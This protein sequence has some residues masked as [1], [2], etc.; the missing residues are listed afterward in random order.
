MSG[1]SG[2][3][4]PAVAI[5]S[6]MAGVV[7]LTSGDLIA[8]DLLRIYSPF[9]LMLARG[10]FAFVPLLIALHLTGT[11]SRLPTRRPVAQAGRGLAMATAYCCYL[12]ALRT[13]PMADATALMFAAPFMVAGLSRLVLGERVSPARWAAIAVGFAGV[14]VVAQP[15]GAGFRAEGLWA[16]GG[17]GALA[18]A[19]LLARRLGATEPATVTTFYTTL[20]MTALGAAPLLLGGGPW[21][22]PEGG[23]VAAIA[24]AG[25]IAGSAHF[26]IAYAY[27]RG[28]ASLVAPFEY[29]ALPAAALLGYLAFGDVP[30]REVWIGMATIACAGCLLARR[31]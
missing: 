12:M 19:A 3:D 7:M 20:A 11:W 24:A 1:G 23:H 2:G 21:V 18:L 4:R 17:A 27:R 26:L 25:L 13:L 31:A 15:G 30:G 29:V 10:P 5:G 28:E 14:L 16:L 6:V 22:A 9:E 8:K